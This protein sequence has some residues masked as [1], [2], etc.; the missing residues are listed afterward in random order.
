MSLTNLL[1][2]CDRLFQI[3]SLLVFLQSNHLLLLLVQNTD[4]VGNLRVLV[5]VKGQVIQWR[6]GLIA[7]GYRTQ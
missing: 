5:H 1:Q 2:V 4:Y 3:L 6:D 7:A